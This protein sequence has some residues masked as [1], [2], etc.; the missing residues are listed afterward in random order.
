ML[1]RYLEHFPNRSHDP[2]ALQ[3]VAYEFRQ[4]VEYRDAFEAHCQWYYAQAEKNQAELASMKND[5]PLLSWL[6]S[7]KS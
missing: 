4:E 3:Q 2:L 5:I 1:Q 6:Y 7:H